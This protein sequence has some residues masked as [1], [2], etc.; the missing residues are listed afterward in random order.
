MLKVLFENN[1]VIVCVKPAGVLSQSAAD[2]RE[3]TDMLGLVS[4]YI[5]TQA[6]LLHRLDRPTGGI[7]VFSKNKS[8]EGVLS[9][10]ISDKEKCIKEYFAVVSGEPESAEGELRDY[11][12][13]DQRQGKS[14]A[15]L[16]PR[17]GAKE[18]CLTYKLLGTA[19]GEHGKISLVKIRLGTGRTH[20]IRVQFSF[21]TMPVVGDGKYG[22]R[23]RMRGET[24]DFGVS[25]KDMIALHAYRLSLDAGKT[26][27]FDICSF[28]DKKLYPFS[29]FDNILTDEEQNIK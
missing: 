17:K 27:K 2:G 23:E 12:F 19:D 15:V 29:V 5:G 22:S 21:R 14:F 11:L 10:A 4:D 26:A 18:A 25:P 24:S 20:Q 28:P 7:M 1:N 8:T 6:G 9:A 16:S 13:K 3:D